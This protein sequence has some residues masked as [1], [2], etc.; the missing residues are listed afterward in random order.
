MNSYRSIVI[1]QKK[2]ITD[3]DKLLS[4]LSEGSGDRANYIARKLDQIT[5]STGD[6]MS[7]AYY[8]ELRKKGIITPAVNSQLKS[9]GVNVGN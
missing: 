4:S 9:L 5:K 8:L 6:A 2:G 1:E 3:Q 7:H